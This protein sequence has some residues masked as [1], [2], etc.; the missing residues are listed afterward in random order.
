MTEVSEI[1]LD[2]F[3]GR[4]VG[5]MRW[6]QLDELWATL[7]NDAAN[8]WYI[9][10]IGEQ[11]PEQTSNSEQLVSFVDQVDQLLRQEHDEDYCGIVYA[12]NPEKPSFIKIFDPNNLGVVCGSSDNPPMPGWV[13]SKIKP[14]DLPEAFPPPGNRR[15]WWQKIFA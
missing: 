5:I 1:F 7:R 8:D 10:A 12:D 4:F 15:R 14:V 6:P 11:P 3:K 9:Y 13:L 2:T